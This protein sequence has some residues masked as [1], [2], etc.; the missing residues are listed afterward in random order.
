MFNDFGEHL[1]RG[2]GIEMSFDANGGEASGFPLWDIAESPDSRDVNIALQLDSDVAQLD[3]ALR[4]IGNETDGETGTQ[5]SKHGFRGI[6]SGILTEQVRWLI[7]NDGLEIADVG[8]IAELAFRHRFCPESDFS[9][10]WIG[11]PF[12]N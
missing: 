2:I 9:A 4:G 3:T 6:W 11:F 7:D 1:G 12:L 10:R 5:G 8:Q